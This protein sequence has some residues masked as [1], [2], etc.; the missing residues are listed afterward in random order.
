VATA[1]VVS[2][3]TTAISQEWLLQV[4]DY[5]QQRTAGTQPQKHGNSP[6]PGTVV[7]W[8]LGIGGTWVV[9]TLMV[10]LGDTAELGVAFALVL[11]GT[12]LMIH[13]PQAL[14]N[15]GFITQKGVPSG[16]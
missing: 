3:A 11:M 9:L 2:F 10:D 7:K 8:L 15:L 1:V 13:G 6:P 4:R 16:G 5:I 12:V 14:A